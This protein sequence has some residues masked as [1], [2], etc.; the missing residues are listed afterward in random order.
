M[1]VIAAFFSR[2]SRSTPRSPWIFTLSIGTSN[3]GKKAS[4]SEVFPGVS[5]LNDDDDVAVPI[6]ICSRI[7]RQKS[8]YM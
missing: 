1:L 3:F 8:L 2:L 4:V 6:W 7:F 5:T